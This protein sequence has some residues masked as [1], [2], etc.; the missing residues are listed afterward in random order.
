MAEITDFHSSHTDS[1]FE[2]GITNA[3]RLPDTMGASGQVLVSNGSRAQWQTLEQGSGPSG[4]GTGLTPEQAQKLANLPTLNG[5]T[6]L[7]AGDSLNA[8]N[9]WEGGF[10]NLIREDYPTATVHNYAVTGSVLTGGEIFNYLAIAIAQNG[11]TP[12]VILLDGGGNDMMQ[13]KPIGTIGA[14]YGVDWS[15]AT[16]VSSLET[17]FYQLHVLTPQAKLVFFPAWKLPPSQGAETSIPA[18]DAQKQWW[19]T[20]RELCEKYNVAYVDFYNNG[21]VIATDQMYHAD[22]IHPNEAGY[23]KLWPMLKAALLWG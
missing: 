7:I 20:I 10:A 16:V 9:G 11:I 14:A 6:I 4:G 5:K 19:A 1:E 12:D 13:S 15:H 2:Q 18:Y 21:G 23:R 17:I 8:G 3:L 22:F